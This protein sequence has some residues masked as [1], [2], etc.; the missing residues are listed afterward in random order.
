MGITQPSLDISTPASIPTPN[1]EQTPISTPMKQENEPTS[2]GL[3]AMD[4]DVVE[5]INKDTKSPIGQPITQPSLDISTLASIP[6]PNKEKA[7]I[8]CSNG[9]EVMDILN[10]QEDI[11]SSLEQKVIE[12][13]S[14][15]DTDTTPSSIKQSNSESLSNETTKEKNTQIKATQDSLT[16][17]NGKETILKNE[18]S[19]ITQNNAVNLPVIA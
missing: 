3:E 7:I 2:S 1:V 14:S 9:T 8:P 6:I 10:K 16:T 13:P 15:N 11:K 12:Q 5:P 19:T 4:T 18:P 17:I